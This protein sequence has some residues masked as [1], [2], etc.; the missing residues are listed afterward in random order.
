MSSFIPIGATVIEL[1]ESKK[2]KKKKKN[3]ISYS[4]HIWCFSTE[5][6]CMQFSFYT[7]SAIKSSIT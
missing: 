1:R 2:K 3:N 4:L 6:F 7:F 5:I